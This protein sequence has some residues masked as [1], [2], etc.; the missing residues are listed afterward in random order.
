MLPDRKTFL[1]L[2]LR[3]QSTQLLPIIKLYN[4]HFSKQN[5]LSPPLS[6]PPFTM[7]RP[8]GDVP[9]CDAKTSLTS[10]EHNNRQV[11]RL[12]LELS[13]RLPRRP[14]QLRRRYLPPDS[15]E[16]SKNGKIS[17]EMEAPTRTITGKLSANNMHHYI[18]KISRIHLGWC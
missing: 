12:S 6:S 18:S 5:K 4:I 9:H 2:V 17:G 16:A 14:P 7:Y 10:I 1:R 3:K 11:L 13:P 15:P 8:Y